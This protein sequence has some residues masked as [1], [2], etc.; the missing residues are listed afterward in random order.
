MSYAI[1][2]LL[3]CYYLILLQISDVQSP[4]SG[5]WGDWSPWMRE[6]QC[7]VSD[8]DGN[9]TQTANF[10]CRNDKNTNLKDI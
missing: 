3:L 6:R 2:S 4:G 7:I 1:Q 8:C 5:E 9:D 10:D